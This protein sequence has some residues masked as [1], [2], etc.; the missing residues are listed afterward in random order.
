MKTL[1]TTPRK[2]NGLKSYSVTFHG[3]RSCQYSL[4][5]ESKPSEDFCG[6]LTSIKFDTLQDA[7]KVGDA[8]LQSEF[9]GI[10]ACREFINSIKGK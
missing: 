1:E 5:L 7:Q 9:H 6:C 10:M 2:T 8:F 4:N 3:L